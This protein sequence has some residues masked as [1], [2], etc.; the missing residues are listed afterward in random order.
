MNS[1]FGPADYA[2]LAAY[3]AVCAFVGWWAGRGQKDTKDYF[4]GGGRMPMWAVCLSILATETSA[5]TFC[6]VPGQAFTKDHTYLQLIAGYI[7][8][9]ILV[10][11]VFLPAFFRAGVTTVYEYLGLRFGDLTRGLASVAFLATRTMADGVRLTAA[12]I[13]MHAATGWDFNLCIVLFAVVTVVYSVF[14]GIKSII[15][16]DVL[17]FF[18][19]VGGGLLALAYI[20]ATADGG[21]AGL[22]AAIPEGK[23]RMIDAAPVFDR[24]FT[25]LAALIAAPVFTLATHGTDQDLAQRML[26]CR[27]ALDGKRSVILSG[28]LNVPMVFLFLCVGTALS[29]WYG[30]HPDPSLPAQADR[31]FPH[32]IVT[33]LPVGVRGL[34]IAAVFA[35]AMSTLSSA[36]GA[37]SSTAT[38]D[39]YRRYLR[40]GADETH[41]LR[42]SRVISALVAAGI[43]GV[44]LGVKDNPSLLNL[45]LEIMTYAY[46]ALLGVFVLGTVTRRGS[47]AGNVLAMAAG[48]GAVIAA[49]NAQAAAAAFGL[50][51]AHGIAWPWYTL[52]G[53]SVTVG[54]GFL[55][56]SDP[57]RLGK[58]R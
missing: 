33:R 23:M 22:W 46:G 47:D 2:V 35:A 3:F 5:L 21:P 16:T 7:L 24:P 56:P 27:G 50:T 32:F 6:S 37:L 42:A 49:E 58:L 29:V 52:I 28:I 11:T 55:F 25:L 17:Q 4:K 41:Y 44:A 14:G 13:A 45:G 12:S 1:T 40:A 10:G 15:W 18:L 39:V 26:T 51:L 48:V 9:R 34:V 19:F 57:E 54:I 38:V 20:A 36:V 31:V 30:A 53:M 43:V 8:G